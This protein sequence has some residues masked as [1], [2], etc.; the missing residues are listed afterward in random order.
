VG[1]EIDETKVN[2]GV[3]LLMWI[4]RLNWNILLERPQNGKHI[5]DY[6]RNESAIT[7]ILEGPPNYEWNTDWMKQKKLKMTTG[8]CKI[9]MTRFCWKWF[10]IITLLNFVII[11]AELSVSTTWISYS[12]LVPC[13][14]SATDE[15]PWNNH[16]FRYKWNQ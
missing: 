2:S 9:F 12:N 1:K 14:T 8:E 4:H 10:R 16:I 3:L 13:H 6:L 11:G 15:V 7:E 5:F